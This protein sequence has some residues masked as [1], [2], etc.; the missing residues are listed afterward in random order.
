MIKETAK[1]ASILML[2]WTKK[3]LALPKPVALLVLV[4]A[5][6]A[7][8]ATLAVPA[9][10]DDFSSVHS[11]WHTDLCLDV[12]YNNQNN[13]T[14]VWLYHCN[15][16][17]AQDWRFISLGQNGSGFERFML[18]DRAGYCLDA[19]AQYHNQAGHGVQIW[20][21]NG[22]STQIWDK[23]SNG[24]CWFCSEKF[25]LWNEYNHLTL[26]DAGWGGQGTPAITYYSHTQYH[27]DAVGTNQLWYRG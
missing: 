4:T 7:G 20:W 6:S 3:A 21:C 16:T 19:P 17:M 22:G 1:S 25:S 2:R 18:M 5:L 13:R 11:L 14:P 15:G 26:D 10:A 23:I 24:P 27:N 8:A 9:Q 12:Q